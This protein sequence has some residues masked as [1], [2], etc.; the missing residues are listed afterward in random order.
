MRSYKT[1]LDLNNNQISDCVQ[2][3]GAARWAYNWGLRRCIENRG[4]GIKHPSAIDLHKELIALKNIPKEEGGCPWMKEISKWVA[5]EALRHLEGAYKRFFSNCKN[6]V[7]G[8]KGFPKFKS[9]KNGIG[10]FTVYPTGSPVTDKTIKV[11]RLGVLRLKERGYFP[12]NV[13]IKSATISERAGRWFVAIRTDEPDPI[14]PTGSET[15]GAD[16]GVKSLAV[17]SDGTTFENP[18]VLR[19]ADARLR[20]LQRGLSRKKKGSSNWKKAK[21]ALANEHYRIFCIRNDAIHKVTSAIAKRSEVLGVESLN[22]AGMLRNRC[23]AKSLSDASL[24][25]LLRQL[26]YKINWHGGRLLKIDRWFPSS[27][28]CSGCGSTKEDLKLSDRLYKCSHCGLEID[29]DLNAA[30]NIC[31]EALRLLDET[32]AASSAVGYACGGEGRSA[33]PKKQEPDNHH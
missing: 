11:P 16:V 20:H 7:K 27:K 23:I 25:E 24:G 19:K 4:L 8:K 13:I 9:R 5:Q 33:P 26:E 14:R 10:S 18:R 29:R 31:V 15:L 28:K 12:I 2:F 6:G 17:L 21:V 1:E 32:R 3:S 30:I 22:I